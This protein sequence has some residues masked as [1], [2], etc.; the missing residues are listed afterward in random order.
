M[1]AEARHN[2]RTKEWLDSWCYSWQ[3]KRENLRF[4]LAALQAAL[5]AI[6][7]ET[8]PGRLSAQ[9]APPHPFCFWFGAARGLSQEWLPDLHMSRLH[10]DKEG[11]SNALWRRVVASKGHWKEIKIFLLIES[12]GHSQNATDVTVCTNPSSTPHNKFAECFVLIV[13]H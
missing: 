13:L 2:F 9:P 10:F 12:S 11:E 6:R 4:S 7:G 8:L 3:E 5:Q 1:E